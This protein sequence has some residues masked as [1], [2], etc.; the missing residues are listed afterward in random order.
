MEEFDGYPVRRGFK[1]EGWALE[2]VIAVSKQNPRTFKVPHPRNAKLVRVGALLRL[3]FVITDSSVTEEGESPRAER[4]WVEV[5]SVSEDGSFLGHLTNEPA[6][7]NSLEP[8][9]VLHFE[10]QHVAQIDKSS[11]GGSRGSET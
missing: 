1:G 11:L 10:W 2:D 6:F 9:D 7:I 4:M 8:G 3:H 5:C